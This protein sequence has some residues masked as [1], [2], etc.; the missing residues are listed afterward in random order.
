MVSTYLSVFVT[1]L[2]A[3]TEMTETGIRMEASTTS[4]HAEM[5]RG[6]CPRRVLAFFALADFTGFSAAV[7]G[8]ASGPDSTSFAS[9]GCI[10]GSVSLIWAFPAPFLL[11]NGLVR[12]HFS[13]YD[14]RC[15]TKGGQ[16]H[17]GARGRTQRSLGFRR[18]VGVRE[19]DRA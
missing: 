11:R 1:V 3:H 8:L 15:E 14:W 5:R 2:M 4:T 10:W 13:V 7:S 12:T 18:A 16:L 6:R 17:R 9:S 19:C